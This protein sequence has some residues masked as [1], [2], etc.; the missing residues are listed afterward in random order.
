MLVESPDRLGALRFLCHLAGQTWHVPAPSLAF[1]IQPTGMGVLSCV[2]FSKGEGI[3]L[4]SK[5][6]SRIFKTFIFKEESPS[7][8]NMTFANSQEG[9]M[10]T[11]H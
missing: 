11:S 5:R 3:G 1:E 9:V 10:A 7:V 4:D 2:A 6:T 8:F